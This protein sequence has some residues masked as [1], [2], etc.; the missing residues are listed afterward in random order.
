MASVLSH[1]KFCYVLLLSLRSQFFSENGSVWEVA[2]EILGRVEVGEPGIRIQCG[3]K[4]II[5][6]KRQKIK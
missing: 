2:Q 5:S 3:R 6:N 4:T 1:I